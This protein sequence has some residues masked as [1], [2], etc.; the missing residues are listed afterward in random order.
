MESNAGPAADLLAELF[1]S[2]VRAAVLGFVLPRPHLG[3]SL[4]DLSRRLELPISSLQH[5]C[6]KLERIGV[7]V[8]RRSGNARLYRVDPQCPLHVVLTALI[9]QA[10]GRDACL[11]GA[12]EDVPGLELAFL[13]G[14]LPDDGSTDGAARGQG[15]D[16]LAVET[17][18]RLVLVGDVP[19]DAL[20]AAIARVEEAL[21]LPAGGL[22]FAF[23]Q[24]DDWAARINLRHHYV[25]E[26]LTDL[27]HVLVGPPAR[28]E[29]E[30]A[31]FGPL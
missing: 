18:L 23:F 28:L 8:A 27:S 3:F 2:K 20:E 26:L 5:E 1:S 10:I 19:L 15:S 14:P 6:Y 29:A 21:D 13:S 22:E 30:R 7:L 9:E 11:A 17:P 4:T 16:G 24:P 31:A 12:I 25:Q